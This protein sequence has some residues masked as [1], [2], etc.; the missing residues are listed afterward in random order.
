MGNIGGA[1]QLAFFIAPLLGSLVISQLSLGKYLLGIG[2]TAASVFIAFLLSLTLQEPSAEVGPH[3][4]SSLQILKEGLAQITRSRKVQWI[5]A[6]AVL[7]ST[8]SSALVT[9]Y[10]PYF[11]KA[12]IQSSLPIGAALALGGLAA[13]LVQKNIYA[14]EHRLGRWGLFVLSLLPG[15][16]F[17]LF[18]FAANIFSLLPLFVLTYAFADAKNPL[19]SAYQNEQIDSKSRATTISLINMLIKLY[20]AI[21]GLALGWVANTS[22]PAA[23]IIIGL[24]IIC[25]TLALRVDKISA[26][27]SQEG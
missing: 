9:L 25:A 13:F 20:V 4:E 12:G 22:I 21:I 5:A 27:L 23:F 2:L 15:I 26:H 6:V 16:F 7:T 18:A 11:V 8:F 14:I 1:Y 24:L 10:Q 3:R 19:I 17:L